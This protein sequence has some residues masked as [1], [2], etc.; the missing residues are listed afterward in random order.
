MAKNTKSS[1][2]NIELKLSEH[3]ENE[4]LRQSFKQALDA[5]E[6][7]AEKLT[8][9]YETAKKSAKN[10]LNVEKSSRKLLRIKISY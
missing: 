9:A 2:Y 3:P 6:Q 8:K 1:Q 4:A 5:E 7:Q 10:T